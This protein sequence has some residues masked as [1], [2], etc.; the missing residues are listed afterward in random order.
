M[1]LEEA[2]AHH[3]WA[4]ENSQGEVRREHEQYVKWLTIA[5]N[6]V[7]KDLLSALEEEH[8]SARESI[9]AYEYGSIK[10]LSEGFYDYARLKGF[11]WGM[12]RAIFLLN[13]RAEKAG[14]EVDE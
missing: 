11:S 3:E 7:L 12:S 10:A 5:K 8:D 2:I 6:D 9:I 4:A 1:T 14:I 13:Y